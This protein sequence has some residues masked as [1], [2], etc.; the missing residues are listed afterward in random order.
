MDLPKL[1]QS[2][3]VLLLAAETPSSCTP[4]AQDSANSQINAAVA[5]TRF[6]YQN[7][8]TGE[9]KISSGSMELSY[10]GKADEITGFYGLVR[11]P[12]SVLR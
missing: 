12:L 1:L 4:N 11:A 8:D 5:P 2:L 9:D 3:P 7:E 6:S 10:N